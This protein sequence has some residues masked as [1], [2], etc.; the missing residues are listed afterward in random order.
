[1]KLKNVLMIAAMLAV[2]AVGVAALYFK[3][4]N[5]WN[6]FEPETPAVAAFA[7]LNDYVLKMKKK[8]GK[9][10]SGW[11]V[12]DV[13]RKEIPYI[14][15]YYSF[16]NDGYQAAFW[17]SEYTWIYDSASGRVY[18][19]TDDISRTA[20]Y[21]CA[22]QRLIGETEAKERKKNKIEYYRL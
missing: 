11:N 1:M 7:P 15:I 4:E 14:M 6:P 22:N 19:T 2:L 3:G 18:R 10:P 13:A 12:N 20:W 16:R 9:Y 17:D 5:D 21:D 8:D